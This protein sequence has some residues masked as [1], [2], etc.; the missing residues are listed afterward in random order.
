LQDTTTPVRVALVALG[1][2]LVFCYA[3]VGP[4][5]Q[6]GLALATSLA[7]CVNLLVLYGWLR[8]RHGALPERTVGVSL[9]R[10]MLASAGMGLFCAFLSRQLGLMEGQG[11][12]MQVARVLGTVGAGMAGYLGLSWLLRAEELAEVYTLVTGRRLKLSS[13]AM[14]APAAYSVKKN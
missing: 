6:G 10:T 14:P 2:N 13:S 7:S 11:L 1:T 3:L 8:W 5:E 4:L 12:A 9:L